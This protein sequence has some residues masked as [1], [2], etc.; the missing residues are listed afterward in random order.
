[1]SQVAPAASVLLTRA[2]GSPEVFVVR[3]SPQLRFFGGFW[4]FPGGKV[5]PADLTLPV[6][7]TPDDGL[8]GRRAAAARELFEE[9]GV[10]VARRADG[11]LLAADPRLE[12]LRH[13]LSAQR[14][15]FADVLATVCASLHADDFAPIGSVTT[16]AFQPLRFDTT[17][18]VAAL[19][20][21]QHAKVHAGELDRG[22]WATAAELLAR[23]RRGRCLVSPPTVMTLSAI[24]DRPAEEAP[25]RLGPLLA[26]LA[27]GAIHPIYFAPDV[28]LIPVRTPNLPLSQHVNAYLVGRDP[29]YLIDPG[30][31]DAQEQSRLF[32]LLDGRLAE[33]VRLA[34]VV[35]THH[36]PDHVGAA[37]ECADRY[38]VPVWAHP[39]TADLLRGRI[40]VAQLLHD[41]DRLDLGRAADGESW[42]LE[43]VFTPGH[44]PGHLAFYEPHY[45][46][47]LAGDMVSTLSS[48]VIAPPEGDLTVYLDSLRRLQGYDCHLLLPSHGGASPRPAEVLAE[49]LAHRARREAQLLEALADGP[50]SAAELAARLYTGLPAEVERFA[51][52]QTVAGLLKLEREGKARARPDDD[53]PAEGR[54][55]FLASSQ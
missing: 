14:V 22:E 55:Y 7:L 52:L 6:A 9:T 46:L 45:R 2:P 23:W 15:T 40:T 42:S 41:G 25:A 37:A 50:Q 43:A 53:A 10:L 24:E 35:L 32:A 44:A 27:A 38:R 48:V 20:P 19:P 31:D 30:T 28:Q 51:R 36:H 17:F 11:S 13:D 49:A 21:G 39:T 8:N 5:D 18:F 1:M 12:S 16:P 47:L 54:R 26:S 3:R 4:A 33:G 29:A 34:A